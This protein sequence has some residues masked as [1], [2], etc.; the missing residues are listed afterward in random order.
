[1][2]D[3]INSIPEEQEDEIRRLFEMMQ[4]STPEQRTRIRE[5]GK[6]LKKKSPQETYT[7]RLSYSSGPATLRD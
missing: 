5:Q 1:M 2:A 7:M 4:L 6:R 3:R